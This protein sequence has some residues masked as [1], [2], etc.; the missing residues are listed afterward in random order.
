MI[1]KCHFKGIII[2]IAIGVNENLVA[3]FYAGVWGHFKKGDGVVHI[4]IVQ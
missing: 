1:E 3:Y 2:L 4:K